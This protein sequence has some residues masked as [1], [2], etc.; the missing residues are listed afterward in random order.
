IDIKPDGRK[1]KVTGSV[2][3]ALAKIVPKDLTGAVRA[4]PDEVI[5]GSAEEDPA[6]RFE[7]VSTITLTLG[8]RATIDT[9]GLTGRLGG[10][11]T[12]RSGYDAVTRATGELSIG[13]G[14]DTAYARKRG[15][16]RG[17]LIFA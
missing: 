12:V 13:G 11:I 5:V 4:T 3:L 15:R 16:Q 7:V 2:R 8:D 6:K 17:R 10:S 1:V 9:F 14:K